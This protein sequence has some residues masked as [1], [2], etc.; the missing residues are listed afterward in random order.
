MSMSMSMS[1][2]SRVKLYMWRGRQWT[3]V[4]SSTITFLIKKRVVPY[5]KPPLDDFFQEWVDGK[6]PFGSWPDH[7]LSYAAMIARGEVLV[8]RYEDMVRDLPTHVERLVKFL[9][10]G[11]GDDDDDNDDDG[12]L[13]K[14]DWECLLPSFGFER[15]KKDL[16]GFHSAQVGDMET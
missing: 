14:D 15:M 5:E 1:S 12:A 2:M 4:Y 7:L 3:H 11:G 16:N 6:I 13:T 9:D 10:L 8:L